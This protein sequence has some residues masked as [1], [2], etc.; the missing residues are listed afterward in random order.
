VTVALYATIWIALALFVAAEAGR[1]RL[2][3]RD[4]PAAWARPALILGALLMTTHVLI[5]LASRYGWDHDAAVRE[6]ARQAATVYGFEWRGNIYVSYAFVVLWFVEIW[7][8]PVPADRD[9]AP[10]TTIGWALRG[11][12]VL[13]IFNGAVVFATTVWSRALGSL[14]VAILV[15]AWWPMETPSLEAARK[16]ELKS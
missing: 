16:L 14:L 4:R 9:A 12:F 7:R 13:I 2:S 1:R 11:F 8:W 15:W 6:T 5:A 10:T 3:D